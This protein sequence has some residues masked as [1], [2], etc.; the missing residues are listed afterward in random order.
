MDPPKADPP[1]TPGTLVLVM[2]HHD[3]DTPGRG[4]GYA[5]T[6]TGVRTLATPRGVQ[7]V[8]SLLYPEGMT[9]VLNFPSPDLEGVLSSREAEAH[10]LLGAAD[11]LQAELQT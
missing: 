6:V 1:P 10:L 9:G 8:L 7:V 4:Y 3:G 2:Q 11:E 5:A